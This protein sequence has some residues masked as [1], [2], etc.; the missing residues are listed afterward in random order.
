MR[1]ISTGAI[2]MSAAGRQEQLYQNRL[3]A[4]LEHAQSEEATAGTTAITTDVV[5]TTHARHGQGGG[6]G[7]GRGGRVH[8]QGGQGHGGHGYG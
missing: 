2:A 8:G 3:A 6:H 1:L 4:R 5:T 7:H